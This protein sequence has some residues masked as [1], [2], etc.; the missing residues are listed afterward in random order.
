VDTSNISI[1]IYEV[2]E[3]LRTRWVRVLLSYGFSPIF[4]STKE[5]LVQ[6]IVSGKYQSVM[7]RVDSDDPSLLQALRAFRER[8]EF[9]HIQFLLIL[10]STSQTFVMDLIKLGFHHLVGKNQPD[11]ALQERLDKVATALGSGPDRRQF[12]RIPVA[13]YE[14]AKL[15]LTLPNQRKVTSLIRNI[16]IGGIQ[17]G[18]RER[19]FVRF[20]SG[21][22]MRDCL[23]VFKDLDMSCDVKV[24]SMLDKG[25]QLQFHQLDETRLNLVARF[26][27]DRIQLG[28]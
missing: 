12:V 21:E 11:Q 23:M 27:Q 24:V 22:I 18:F 26:I 25:L 10:E 17:V 6:G 5:A 2:Q 15:I 16:S 9:R 20:N 4:V 8:P 19:I 7:S 14:N 1:L 28:V 3:E 13:E